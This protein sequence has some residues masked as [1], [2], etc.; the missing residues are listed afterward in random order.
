VT[1]KVENMRKQPE[2]TLPHLCAQQQVWAL[3]QGS[4]LGANKLTKEPSSTQTLK[5]FH[6]TGSWGLLR[7]EKCL[8]VEEGGA[9]CLMC[10]TAPVEE[11]SAQDAALLKAAKEKQLKKNSLMRKKK[12][13]TKLTE[14]VFSPELCR[15]LHIQN[16]KE[17]EDCPKCKVWLER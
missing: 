8:P 6:S 12:G 11:A 17:K 3:M 13:E 1:L 4:K 5:G 10:G 14:N 15:P 9:T 16:V 7:K 2:E